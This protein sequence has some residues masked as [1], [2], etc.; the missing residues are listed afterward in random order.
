MKA[1]IDFILQFGDLNQQQLDLISKKAT[2]RLLPKDEYF[3]EAGKIAQEVGFILDGIVRVCYYNNKGEEITKYFIDENNLVVDLESFDNEICSNAYV[4][5]ITDCKMLVFSKKDWQELLDTII[6]WEA[7]VNK[8]ISR[9]LRQKVERRSPLVTE[10]ATTRYLMF[11]KIYPNVV[12]RIPLSYVASY[13]GITQ[14]SLSRI[15]KN[16]Q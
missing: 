13:L 15:R 4:Q 3:S 16:I 1:F 6:P 9:A 5:A 10:D 8:I 12:N 2:E 11:L 7:I 14:S